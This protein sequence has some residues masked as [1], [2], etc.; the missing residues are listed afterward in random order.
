MLI[1][2]ASWVGDLPVGEALGGEGGDPAFRLAERGDLLGVDPQRG[3]PALVVGAPAG[4]GETALLG[5]LAGPARRHPA[6]DG[7]ADGLVRRRLAQQRQ[8]LRQRVDRG[9]E[10]R[11]PSG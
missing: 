2:T 3:R 9:L 5:D 6:L 10:L 7:V 4:A 8:P 1:V 11:D